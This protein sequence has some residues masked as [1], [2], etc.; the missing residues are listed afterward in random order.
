[1]KLP[2]IIEEIQL[3][4]EDG[5]KSFIIYQVGRQWKYEVYDNSDVESKEAS[6]K[7]YIYIKNSVDDTAILVN[8]KRDFKEYDLKSLHSQI[9][10]M[11]AKKR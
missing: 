6:E 5:I 4:L 10:K 7:K 9:K 3:D 11:K 8:G 1:M 2:E